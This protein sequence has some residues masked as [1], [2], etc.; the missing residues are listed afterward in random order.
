MASPL[1]YVVED[2]DESGEMGGRLLVLGGEKN[3]L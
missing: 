2:L 3:R 1:A